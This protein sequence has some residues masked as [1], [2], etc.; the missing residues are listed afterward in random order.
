VYKTPVRLA[1]KDP[2]LCIITNQIWTYKEIVLK[3]P[4]HIFYKCPFSYSQVFMHTDGQTDGVLIDSLQTCKYLTHCRTFISVALE[5]G[6]NF[7]AVSTISL[8]AILMMILR[9]RTNGTGVPTHSQPHAAS[10][11]LSACNITIQIKNRFRYLYCAVSCSTVLIQLILQCDY[12][13]TYYMS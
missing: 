4:N 1:V 9:L 6:T 5:T 3:P 10:L 7:P 8:L 12:L 13:R 2:L 11:T